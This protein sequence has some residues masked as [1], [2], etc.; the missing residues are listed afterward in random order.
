MGTVPA[1]AQEL[2]VSVPADDVPKYLAAVLRTYKDNAKPDERLSKTIAR[3]GFADFKKEVVTKLELPYD[4]LI[5]TAKEIREKAMLS[6]CIDSL[7][8]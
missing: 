6:E 4:D 3:I 7:Q 5:E 2:A 1:I 8:K